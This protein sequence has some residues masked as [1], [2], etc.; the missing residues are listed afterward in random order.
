LYFYQVLAPE[1]ATLA[2]AARDGRWCIREMKA[3]CNRAVMP[4]TVRAVAAWLESA[5]NQR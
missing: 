2:V 5:Q 4:A 1:R 3:T